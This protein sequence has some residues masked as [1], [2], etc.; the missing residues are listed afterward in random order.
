MTDLQQISINQQ[1]LNKRHEELIHS[2]KH[3][4]NTFAGEEKRLKLDSNVRCLIACRELQKLL[5]PSSEPSW[6]V[7]LINWSQWYSENYYL[8][9]ANSILLM[10]IVELKSEAENFAFSLPSSPAQI[11]SE[12]LT[13]R[14]DFNLL[15]KRFLSN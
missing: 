1:L 5:L 4:I 10:Y 3:L 12:S 13:E 14:Q 9:D 8:A 6:L 2:I 11:A 7:N 15:L